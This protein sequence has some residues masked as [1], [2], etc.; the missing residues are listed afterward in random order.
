MN[1]RKVAFKKM[2]PTKK[3]WKLFREKVKEWQERYIA[4]INQEY[5]ALLN[6]DM[7]PSSKFWELDN[8]IKNDR[9][10]PGVIIELRKNRMVFDIAMFIRDGIIGDND[11]EGFTDE[12]VE[13]VK[14]IGYARM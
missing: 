6:S 10:S 2:E 1:L 5:I 8:R 12:L 14:F 3:D 4:S 11:L 9:K 7:P 13:E